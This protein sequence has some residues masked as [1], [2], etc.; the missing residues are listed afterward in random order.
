MLISVENASVLWVTVLKNFEGF[1]SA[2]GIQLFSH[3]F[4]LY[5]LPFVNKRERLQWEGYKRDN[6]KT[7][8]KILNRG[9]YTKGEKG[10]FCL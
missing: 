1:V 7:N 5:H 6:K 2:F 9:G 10:S 3:S 8:V 4:I